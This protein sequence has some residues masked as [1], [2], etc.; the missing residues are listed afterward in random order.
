MLKAHTEG[1]KKKAKAA[2]LD[3]FSECQCQYILLHITYY[4]TVVAV[5]CYANLHESE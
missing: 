2:H 1:K 3:Y 5:C 4:G